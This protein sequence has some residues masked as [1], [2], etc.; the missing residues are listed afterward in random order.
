MPASVTPKRG[1]EVVASALSE[2]ILSRT[3]EPDAV[4]VESWAP[5]SRRL[6]PASA[7]PTR[8]PSLAR[9]P[10]R[11]P[12]PP[13][14]WCPRN[15]PADQATTLPVEASPS[16][17]CAGGQYRV[18]TLSHRVTVGTPHLS[19]QPQSYEDPDG[20][21]EAAVKADSERESGLSVVS[22]EFH[23][24]LTMLSVCHS[25]MF[26][27][28]LIPHRGVFDGR[29]PRNRGDPYTNPSGIL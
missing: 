8:N 5:N 27:D 11:Q 14:V 24:V 20:S 13:V 21:T 2:A 3:D 4:S 23:C 28:A 18:N 22:L 6:I 19:T 12:R 17:C 29:Q 15:S 7:R 25:L 1:D 26:T 16:P 10:T 9:Q